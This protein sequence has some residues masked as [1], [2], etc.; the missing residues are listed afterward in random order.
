MQHSL[1]LRKRIKLS[2]KEVPEINAEETMESES[3]KS[4]SETEVKNISKQNHNNNNLSKIPFFR[5]QI[6]SKTKGAT[7]SITNSSPPSPFNKLNKPESKDKISEEK[8]R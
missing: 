7:E 4:S 1:C 2:L 3:S 5:H 6:I 8:A